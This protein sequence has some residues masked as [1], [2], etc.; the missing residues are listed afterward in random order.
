M[1][2]NLEAL[3]VFVGI[4]GTAAHYWRQH[5][6]NTAYDALRRAEVLVGVDPLSAYEKLMPHMATFYFFKHEP[7][8]T[9]FRDVCEQVEAQL[10]YHKLRSSPPLDTN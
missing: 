10:V 4:T 3:I 6:V 9:R 2:E 1:I 7:Y 5:K 8:F